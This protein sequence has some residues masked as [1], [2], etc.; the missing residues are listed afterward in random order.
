[1]T[2][3]AKVVVS[4]HTYTLMYALAAFLECSCHWLADLL[5]GTRLASPVLAALHRTTW[6]CTEP[7]AD[8]QKRTED[9]VAL[10]TSTRCETYIHS[11]LE[12]SIPSYNSVLEH[13]PSFE[14]KTSL[15]PSDYRGNVCVAFP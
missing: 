9:L 13:I 15:W 14:K 10:F 11:T 2:Y 4:L 8:Q 3:V 7:E 12:V 5:L 1:M 6:V